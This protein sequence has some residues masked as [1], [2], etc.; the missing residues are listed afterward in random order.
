LLQNKNQSA[1]GNTDSRS[2]F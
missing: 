2:D 1:A